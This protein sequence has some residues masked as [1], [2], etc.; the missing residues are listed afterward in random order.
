[1]AYSTDSYD[2]SCESVESDDQSVLW[3]SD[4]Y[5]PEEAADADH[6]VTDEELSAEDNENV[7]DGAEREES[8]DSDES[9]MHRCWSAETV[10]FGLDESFEWHLNTSG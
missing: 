3:D 10:T 8:D 9:I 4:W 5:A 6:E 1:M 7:A 2:S